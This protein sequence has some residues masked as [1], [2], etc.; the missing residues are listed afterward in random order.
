MREGHL[1]VVEVLEERRQLAKLPDEVK[2]HFKTIHSLIS[3]INHGCMDE[4]KSWLAEHQGDL[5]RTGS[6]IE[7]T[8]HKLHFLTLFRSESSDASA[9]AM[10]YIR[11]HIDSTNQAHLKDLSKLLTGA[12]YPDPGNSPY[13][14]DFHTGARSQLLADFISESCQLVGLPCSPMLMTVV[15]AAAQALPGLIR[16]AKVSSEHVWKQLHLELLKSDSG[17]KFHSIFVCP[18]THEISTPENPAMLLPCGH[19]ISSSSLER[20][21]KSSVR[22]T[23]KCPTCPVHCGESE[24]MT[25]KF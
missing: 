15:D 16:F 19:V 25:I 4:A 17:L 13:D 23:V 1:G 8:L 10:Q 14:S 21:I 2:E 5:Q 3:Q 24:A 11:Q 9:T 12:L 18:V 22:S 20:L 7:F 6:D